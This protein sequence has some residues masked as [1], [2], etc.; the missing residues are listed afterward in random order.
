M[1]TFESNSGSQRSAI[2]I[3]AA[4]ATSA[5]LLLTTITLSSFG[6]LSPMQ[7]SGGNVTAPATGGNMTG[8]TNA[9][10]TASQS[11]CANQTQTA[12][13]NMT[14]TPNNMTMT[15]NATMT[16]GGNA[17]GTASQAVSEVRFHIE[18]ACKA[19]QSNDTQ[20]ALMHLNFAMM[21]LDNVQGNLTSTTTAGNATNATMSGGANQTGG[22]PGGLR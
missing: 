22:M 9:T 10:T 7:S 8:A 18:E 15:G 2:Y 13:Q 6:Q 14:S 16:A 17:T 5:L 20:G 19:L 1:D 11:A 4:I 12:G 3:A 21:S